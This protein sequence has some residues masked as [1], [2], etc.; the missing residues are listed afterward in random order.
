MKKHRIPSLSLA[1]MGKAAAAN[2]THA[3]TREVNIDRGAERAAQMIGILGVSC[4]LALLAH[5]TGC[6]PLDL[7]PTASARPT[8]YLQLP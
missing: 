3:K 2:Y 7:A 8:S 5:L 4:L 6:A 1:S